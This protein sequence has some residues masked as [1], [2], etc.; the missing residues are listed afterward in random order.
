MKIA[1]LTNLSDEHPD[2]MRL[3]KVERTEKPSNAA[4]QVYAGVDLASGPDQTVMIRNT[5]MPDGTIKQ[6][7]LSA[8]QVYADPEP[9]AAAPRGTEREGWVPITDGMQQ[10]VADAVHVGFV[11]DDGG[12]PA[13]IDKA[14]LCGWSKLCGLHARFYRPL[15]P[16]KA[17]EW[18]AHDG[19]AKCPV[20]L[21]MLLSGIKQYTRGDEVF[22][23]DG[24]PQ[25]AGS[26]IWYCITF[27]R[28][29]A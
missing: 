8:D 24:E 21:D 27:Y 16:A 13:V 4:A 7:F 18:I 20:P 9:T 2:C 6:E 11:F 14:G 25:T 17:G 22:D 5:L 3:V 1:Y 19:S 10:P 26:L 15:S 28:L 23:W 12:V 29:A